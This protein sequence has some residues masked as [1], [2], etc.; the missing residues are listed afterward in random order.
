[1]TI[2]LAGTGDGCAP[3]PVTGIPHCTTGHNPNPSPSRVTGQHPSPS[4]SRVTGHQPSPKPSRHTGDGYGPKPSTSTSTSGVPT[5]PTTDSTPV[6]YGAL[7]AAVGL[8]AVGV[9]IRMAV[10]RRPARHALRRRQQP[11][12]AKL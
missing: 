6:P 4:P 3:S 1:M 2:F 12:G 9:G 10:R 7:G 8:I 5:L 11:A